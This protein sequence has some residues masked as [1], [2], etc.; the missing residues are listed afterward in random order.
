MPLPLF[1]IDAF[2]DQPFAG[3]PAGVCFLD[4]PRD[5][6]WMQRVAAE[7]NVAETA[8]LV[9]RGDDSFDLRWFTPVVEVSLCGHAT[10]ASAHALWSTGRV[11][12]GR[13]IA[14]ETK[15]GTLRARPADNGITIDLPARPVAAASLPEPIAKALG[16]S[17]IWCGAA[18]KGP[19]GT[20]YLV[21]CA[22]ERDVTEA[23]PD[24]VAL[25]A[26]D[27]GIIL[28]AQGETPGWDVVSRYFVP[29]FGIDEDPVTGSAHCALAT[30]WTRELGRPAFVARQVSPRGGTLG[31]RLEGDRVFLTGRAI[32]V[33][34]G[35]LVD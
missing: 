15:S 18:R 7:M 12:P 8:F 10:L 4:A 30:Y 25:R 31:V 22:G 32:T 17:P 19:G 33:V 1:Q 3:N 11:M 5:A 28:T 20:D 27:G 14:F 24:F 35:E 2:T 6:A 29:A 23:R 9:S 21:R 13:A 16:V 34:R 26:L